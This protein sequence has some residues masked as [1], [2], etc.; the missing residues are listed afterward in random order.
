MAT[1]GPLLLE[2]Q[3]ELTRQQVFSII[4]NLSRFNIRQLMEQSIVSIQSPYTYMRDLPKKRVIEN[5]VATKM[6]LAD[7]NAMGAGGGNQMSDHEP[8]KLN[9]K[10]A[11]GSR[12]QKEALELSAIPE[13]CHDA[14]SSTTPKELASKSYS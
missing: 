11:G 2:N 3:S 6:S 9:I 8:I 4:E 13:T 12:T 10:L 1:D 7:Q 14:K 5:L